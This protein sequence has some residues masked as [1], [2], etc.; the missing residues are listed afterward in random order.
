MVLLYMNLHLSV[1]TVEER[2]GFCVKYNTAQ[3]LARR[4]RL[5][6][7]GSDHNRKGGRPSLTY[8]GEEEENGPFLPLQRTL[9]GAFVA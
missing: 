6:S 1:Q 4:H 2:P 3:Q 5:N 9:R 8:Q 7:G